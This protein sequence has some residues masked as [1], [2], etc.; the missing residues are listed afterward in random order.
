MLHRAQKKS[1][2]GPTANVL[3]SAKT[4]IGTGKGPLEL[5][6][7]DPKSLED[8]IIAAMLLH[9]VCDT[10]GYKNGEWEFNE[11]EMPIPEELIEKYNETR[12]DPNITRTRIFRFLDMGGVNDINLKDWSVSDDTMLNVMTARGLVIYNK[13]YRSTKYINRELFCDVMSFSYRFLYESLEQLRQKP[14]Y[15]DIGIQPFNKTI[16]QVHGGIGTIGILKQFAA[17]MTWRDVHPVG[18]GVT[19]GGG[20]GAAIRTIP[21]GLVYWGQNNRQLLIDM[22]LEASR[23]THNNP[24]GY[25]GGI[26][27]ALFTAFAIEKIPIE[28]WISEMLRLLIDEDNTLF[29]YLR[30]TA[31]YREFKRDCDFWYNAWATYKQKFF[32]G[33]IFVPNKAPFMSNPVE[34]VK[35]FRD[36]LGFRTGNIGFVGRGGHDSVIFAYDAL[37]R[38]VREGCGWEKLLVLSTLHSG[39]SDSTGCIA[40]AWFGAMFGIDRVPKNMLEHLE[41]RVQ[42]ESMAKE[43]NILMLK[44]HKSA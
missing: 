42:T 30:E 18:I 27:S 14:E 38:T 8:N 37:L 35:W 20:N 6:T 36:N 7:I 28:L 32:N 11:P 13:M 34:R 43:L 33:D 24:T 40:G 21:I 39:D 29:E 2:D 5:P 10:I 15:V 23:V 19:T 22:A 31:G 16:Q 4:V 12:Y 1:G 44:I 25:L 26:C 17:G 3:Q 41:H 9:S